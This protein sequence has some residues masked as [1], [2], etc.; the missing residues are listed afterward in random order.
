MTLPSHMNA[1]M[2]L[3]PLL[4]DKARE[5]CYFVYPLQ[6]TD[7][8]AC[9]FISERRD[10]LMRIITVSRQFG[11]GGRELGKRLADHLNWDYYDKE[12]IEALAVENGMNPDLV[13]HTLSHHG[14][15]NVQ[16]TY[17]N[18]F[19]HLGFDHST[20][21]QLLVR[22]R[23]IIREIAEAGNDCIIVGRDADIILYDYHPFRISVCAELDARVARCMR[24]EQKKPAENRLTEK[25]I[26]RNI[27]RIDRNRIRTREVLTGKRHGDPSAF[28]LVVNATRWDIKDLTS[29]VADFA[30]HWFEE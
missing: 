25:D 9:N 15:H 28:D 18:S 30:M 29:A 4:I 11:S 20:R 5:E 24:H 8:P 22:Q 7:S 12:I 13:R 14:W 21:T 17:K 23:E 16:I 3:S 19:A 1:A 26:L 6:A 2:F 10:L 27:R